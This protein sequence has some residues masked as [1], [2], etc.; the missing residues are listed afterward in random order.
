MGTAARERRQ[1]RAWPALDDERDDA[2]VSTTPALRLD[3]S[4]REEEERGSFKRPSAS[5]GTK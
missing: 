2:L 1:G 4:S 5:E 3:A